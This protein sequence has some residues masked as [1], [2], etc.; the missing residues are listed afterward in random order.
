[1]KTNKASSPPAIST[2]PLFLCLL[3]LLTGNC[4]PAFGTLYQNTKASDG[5]ADL[6][7]EWLS[8]S[9]FADGSMIYGKLQ[10]LNTEQQDAG[11]FRVAYYLSLDGLTLPATPFKTVNR[12]SGLKGG[13]KT[14]LTLNHKFSKPKCGKYV[15]VVV[16]SENQVS[17]T[18]EDNN[19]G[20]KK[21]PVNPLAIKG[22]LA[23][24]QLPMSQLTTVEPVFW[25]RNER[26]GRTIDAA[27]ASYD[28]EKATYRVHNLPP[29]EVGISIRFHIT[30]TESNLPGNYQTWKVVDIG[31]LKPT[32]RLNFKIP[33]QLLIHLQQ[34]HD[35]A[36]VD[37]DMNEPYPEHG[38][39]MLFQ[40]EAVPG[41]TTYEVKISRNRDPDH[42]DGYG[43]IDWAKEQ[44]LTATS[45]SIDLPSSLAEEHYRF[46]VH[47]YQGQTQIG[48][49]V[50]IYTNGVGW[51][52]LFKIN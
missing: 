41:A 11:T 31:A 45:C 37:S 26:T 15:I 17:E 52:Y 42:P 36:N 33:M 48:Y 49:Y 51:D 30:G 9:A 6:A 8:L 12:K 14:T 7:V 24:G 10:I 22:Q 35:N 2:M 25:F 16:D 43:F 23:L 47:A 32:E 50:I 4:V 5:S 44:T 40:W 27:A 13:S 46:S 18:R 38:S 1:M 19:S 39:P 21:I 29:E 3:L 34:P 20:K 28:S